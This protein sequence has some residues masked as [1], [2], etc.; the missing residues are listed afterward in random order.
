MAFVSEYGMLAL[1]MTMK[2]KP[3]AVMMGFQREYAPTYHIE[4]RERSALV[5]DFNSLLLYAY[6]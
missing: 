3:Q 1:I 2:N 6:R 5:W 4:L